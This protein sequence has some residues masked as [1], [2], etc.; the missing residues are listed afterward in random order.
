MLDVVSVPG[1]ID[2]LAAKAAAGCPIRILIANPRG[3]WILRLDQ[4]T[5]PVGT[6]PSDELAADIEESREHL[7]SLLGNRGVEIRE[8]L[9]ADPNSILR[10]DDQLLFSPNLW[11]TDRPSAPRLHVTRRQPGG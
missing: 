2:L 1:V 11:L 8:Y 7:T 10:F 4:T 9:E 3:E 5:T 6:L